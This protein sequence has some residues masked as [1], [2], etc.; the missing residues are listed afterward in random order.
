[1]LSTTDLADGSA[2]KKNDVLLTLDGG[3]RS[4]L[5]LS[6]LHL[7]PWRMSGIATLTRKYTELQ[8]G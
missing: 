2:I 5:R 3:A 8:R 4:I 6:G 7:L 1:V